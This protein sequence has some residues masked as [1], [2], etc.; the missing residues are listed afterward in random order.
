MIN[1]VFGNHSARELE[2]N[3]AAYYFKIL[4]VLYEL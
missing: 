2:K 3:M 4:Y 1:T